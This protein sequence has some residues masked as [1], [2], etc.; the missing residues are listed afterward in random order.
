MMVSPSSVLCLIHGVS[1]CVDG[2]AAPERA[3][4]SSDWARSKPTEARGLRTKIVASP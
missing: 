2:V 3:S 4:T 1:R